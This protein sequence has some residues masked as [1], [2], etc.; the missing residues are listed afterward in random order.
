M[1]KKAKIKSL[2]Y[3]TVNTAELRAK[4][5]CGETDVRIFVDKMPADTEY[6]AGKII[7]RNTVP[8][9]DTKKQTG[10]FQI[11]IYGEDPDYLSELAEI[12]D[13][14]LI[15]WAGEYQGLKVKQIVKENDIENPQ[16]FDTKLYQKIL[17]FKIIYF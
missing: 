1:S 13:N 12:I 9:H 5:P 17:E 7:V 10:F 15:G 11:D 8:E 2:I 14:S 3:G 6:P 4:I 16:E